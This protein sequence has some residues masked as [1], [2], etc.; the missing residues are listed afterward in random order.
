[1]EVKRAKFFADLK[2]FKKV[3]LDSS[4]LIYHLEDIRPYSEL[5][6]DLFA[7]LAAGT[8]GAVLSII[9]VTELLTKPFTENQMDRVSEFDSFVLSLPNTDLISPDYSNAREAARLRGRYG[10]R[11]PD[12]L[13]LATGLGAKAD[14]LFTNDHRMRRLKIEGLAVVILDDYV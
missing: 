4:T 12:A 9:S 5:T 3:L 7:A 10:M 8:V 11:T 1:M 2:N 6:E 13:L 14:A